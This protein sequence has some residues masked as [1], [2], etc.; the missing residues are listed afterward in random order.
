M[1]ATAIIIGSAL[2]EIVGFAVAAPGDTTV[3][4]IYSS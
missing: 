1:V 2:D 3:V 4:V